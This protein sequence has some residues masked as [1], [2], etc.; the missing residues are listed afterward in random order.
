MVLGLDLEL[1]SMSGEHEEKQ[2][3]EKKIEFS[4]VSFYPSEIKRIEI[5]RSGN[6]I[7]IERHD[8]SRRIGFSQ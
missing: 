7:V 8:E 4:G 5:E 6:S 1:V 2:K 3:K